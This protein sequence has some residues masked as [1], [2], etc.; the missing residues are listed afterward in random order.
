MLGYSAE[1][2]RAAE[3]PHLEASEPL[4]QRAAEGLAGVLR[5]LLPDGGRILV[6]AGA[7]NNGGDA[8]FAAARLAVDD[9]Y[10]VH[11]LGAS[12]R[13][14]G[15]AFDAAIAAGATLENLEAVP[16][17][18][19]SADVL[20][21]GLVGIGAVPPLRGAALELVERILPLLKPRR[22]IVV[23][24]DIPSGIHPDDGSVSGPLLPADVTVTFGGYK[25]GLLLEPGSTIAGRV[26]LV[27]IGIAA[28]LS[29]FEPLVTR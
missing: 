20:V 23:A 25:A 29:R 13:I 7:G 10:R 27:D 16:A 28:E 17:L 24:V 1:Q 12:E 15:E 6:L 26:E 18:V 5:D 3:A 11:I 22:P 14:H 21:D 9:R 8:M 2:L 19:E 4:M